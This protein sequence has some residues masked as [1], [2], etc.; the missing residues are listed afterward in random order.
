[1]SPIA[2]KPYTVSAAY[3]PFAYKAHR[4][5]VSMYRYQD[6]DNSQSITLY[7][8]GVRQP[9][10][11]LLSQDINGGVISGPLPS[12]LLYQ[13]SDTGG[14]HSLYTGS[15]AHGHVI[16]TRLDTIARVVSGTFEAK[17]REDGGPDSLT[18]TQGR[19]DAKF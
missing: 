9:G 19:F 4:V 17:L 12:H 13:V 16:I 5:S 10:T 14:N 1:M 18:I 11:Y 3:G 2:N 15:N 7:L 6:V 8:A